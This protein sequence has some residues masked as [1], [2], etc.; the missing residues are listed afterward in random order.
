ME[1]Y[2]TTIFYKQCCPKKTIRY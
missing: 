1:L 2:P